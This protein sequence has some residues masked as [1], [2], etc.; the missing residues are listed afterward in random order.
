MKPPVDAPASRQRR[1]STRRP[2]R[3]K[4]SRAPAS[5]C[6]PRDDVVVATRSLGDDDRLGRRDPGRG[7]RRRPGPR[8]SPARP[9]SARRPAR[10]TGPVH[11]GPV[12][13]RAAGVGGTRVSPPRRPGRL[14]A[15]GEPPRRRPGDRGPGCRRDSCECGQ[16][17]STRGSPVLAPGSDS[18]SPWLNGSCSVMALAS[19]QD[20]AVTLVRR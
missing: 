13:R 17:A 9:R 2:W 11:A 12:R 4:T 15:T 7:L 3:A 18:R 6:A 20:V 14:A 1:P 5:L 19:R 16:H 8:H 10:V